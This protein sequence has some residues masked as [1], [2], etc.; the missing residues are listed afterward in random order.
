MK[1]AGQPHLEK[2]GGSVI[3]TDKDAYQKRKSQMRQRRRLDELEE[4]QIKMG[5]DL[6]KL[7]TKLDYLIELLKE[8]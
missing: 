2:H 5:D 3:S 4:K 1:V 6:E 7:N 8:K